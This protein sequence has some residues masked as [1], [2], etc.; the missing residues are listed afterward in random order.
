MSTKEK[1]VVKV[2]VPELVNVLR[3]IKLNQFVGITTDT[4]PRMLK[5]NNPFYDKETK[6]FNV[7][8]VSTTS[9]RTSNYEQRVNNNMENEGMERTFVSEKPKGRTHVEGTDCLLV[10]DKDPNVFYL[11]VE[12]FGNN[13]PDVEYFK[14]GQPMNELDRQ[15]LN[16]FLEK[17]SESTKQEQEKKVS[18]ITP[19]VS[20]IKRITTEHVEYVVE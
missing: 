1:Q 19:L 8:K 17:V 13:K 18:V 4:E 9:Y 12:R 7:R 10:S 15:I 2:T 6:T 20:N 3:T 16:N 11:M 5:T 14:D